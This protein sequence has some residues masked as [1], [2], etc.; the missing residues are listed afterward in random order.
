[1]AIAAFIYW[2]ALAG[3]EAPY[4]AGLHSSRPARTQQ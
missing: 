3:L 2:L 1:V 4:R